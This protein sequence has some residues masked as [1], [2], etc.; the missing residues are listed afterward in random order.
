[1]NG[2]HD[3][4]GM[5]SFGPVAPELNEP[6]FH[7]DWERR[8]FAISNLLGVHDLWTLDADRAACENHPPADYLRMP[9]YDKWLTAMERLLPDNLAPA[10]RPPLRREEIAQYSRIGSSFLRE[11][12]SPQKFR[13]GDRVRARSI[14]PS[15]HTRLPRYLRGHTGEIVTVHG[16][17]VYPDSNAHG[18]GED[19]QWLYTVRFAASEVWGTSSKHCNHADLWEPYLEAL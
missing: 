12:G 13:L 16:R 3:A 5:T 4:G 8:V 17:H 11:P 7:G 15:G 18:G 6:V 19:P 9:Y 2:I 1:M 10:V 14:N